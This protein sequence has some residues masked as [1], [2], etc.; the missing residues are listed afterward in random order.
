MDTKT[1]P[2]TVQAK[3]NA[4]LEKVWKYWTTPEH[5]MNWN[6]AS[7]DWICPEVQNDLEVNGEFNYRMESK[8]GE[9]GFDFEGT[10]YN[11][12]EEE[13]IE[14]KIDDG[15]LV[16]IEFLQDGDSVIV[17][18]T[19]EPEDKNSKELQEN[20]WQAIL[21]NFKKYVESNS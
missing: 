20:G 8:D 21:D 17:T 19:F 6:F 16:S 5:I 11:I 1:Q 10:Y 4:N 13:L 14:Y 15:R 9:M 2:I 18:E 3:V 12:I 7:D